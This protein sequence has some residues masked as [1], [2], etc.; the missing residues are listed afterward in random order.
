MGK[1]NKEDINILEAYKFS[2]A[3]N[4][5]GRKYDDK[6]EYQHMRHYTWDQESN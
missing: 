3:V 1:N 4:S 2:L 5:I 6:F